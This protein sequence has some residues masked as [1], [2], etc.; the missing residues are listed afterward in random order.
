M[1]RRYDL[2]CFEEER[3]KTL[4]Y[5]TKCQS[6]TMV[7]KECLIKLTINNKQLH[8]KTDLLA[9]NIEEI[10]LFQKKNANLV[11]ATNLHFFK[12]AADF[13]IAS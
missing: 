12:N 11:I 9:D 8:F 4:S 7:F 10:P 1:L 13:V 6:V 5:K 3:E 2:N